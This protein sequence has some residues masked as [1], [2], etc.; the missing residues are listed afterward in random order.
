[1]V[2]ILPVVTTQGREEFPVRREL[3]PLGLGLGVGVLK[4]APDRRL[5][6]VAR[7]VGHQAEDP[8]WAGERFLETA[9]QMNIDLDLMWATVRDPNPEPRQVC[10][11]VTG[12]GN[13]LMLFVSG[14]PRRPRGVWTRRLVPWEELASGPIAAGERVAVIR[15]ACQGAVL[16]AGGRQLL[17]QTLLESHETEA[18]T[19]FR[20]AGFQQLGDLAYMRRTSAAPSETPALPPNLHMVSLARLL[21]TGR[22]P[23]QVD[24]LLLRVLEATYEQTLDCPELCGLR[25][26]SDVLESHR[27]V[28]T[29]DPSLWWIVFERDQALGCLLFNVSPEHSAVELVYLGLAKPLRGRGLGTLVLQRG[30]RHLFG[31]SL[32]PDELP[33]RPVV[34]VGGVT[35][36]VD[37]RNYSAMKLYRNAGFTRFGMRV[38]LVLSVGPIGIASVAS[39]SS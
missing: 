21:A 18:L 14:A 15:A 8:L 23:E 9:D 35:C 1:M 2:V 33:A 24:Q 19:G 37:T 7:L 13:T 29:C 36:A 38:P 20:A 31:H 32:E 16:A 5:A 6:A 26:V 12:S 39:S 22:T 28:G 17:A 10:L 11:G 25:A 3:T 30:I 34:G 27:A 4:V